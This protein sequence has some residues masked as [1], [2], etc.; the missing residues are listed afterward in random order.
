MRVLLCICSHCTCNAW[1]L[2]QQAVITL[3]PS[4]DTLKLKAWCGLTPGLLR[5]Q[6]LCPHTQHLGEGVGKCWGGLTQMAEESLKLS[7]DWKRE[8]PPMNYR[9]K[10]YKVF[11]AHIRIP[12]FFS[13]KVAL[14]YQKVKHGKEAQTGIRRGG[15]SK[16]ES[17]GMEPKENHVVLHMWDLSSSF[18]SGNLPRHKRNCYVST[19]PMRWGT[20]CT[21]RERWDQ[22]GRDFLKEMGV[23]QP[24]LN[25]EP[26]QRREGPIYATT[27][28]WG[29]IHSLGAYFP[30][31]Q[32]ALP[33]FCLLLGQHTKQRKAAWTEYKQW[34]HDQAAVF[35]CRGV[36]ILWVQS[37]LS[38]E[39]VSWGMFDLPTCFC[40]IC[41]FRK[42]PRN[43]YSFFGICC[44]FH[45]LFLTSAIKTYPGQNSFQLPI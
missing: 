24:L 16:N 32:N 30:R 15:C 37:K 29:W 17:R 21:Q 34:Q 43:I 14:Y 3:S 2:S 8:S 36:S 22:E 40:S 38:S 42:S 11:R 31:V 33:I 18:T 41:L 19:H 35:L 45:K 7:L 27:A 26:R 12:F 9:M 25:K 5:H 20:L 13:T 23:F 6:R 39:E 44:L 1:V 4:G 10:K 28:T